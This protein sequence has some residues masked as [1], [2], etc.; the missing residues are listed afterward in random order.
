MPLRPISYVGYV[1][2]FGCL[3]LLD[4]FFV[5]RRLF[6]SRVVA[7]D[8]A[9]AAAAFSAAQIDNYDGPVVLVFLPHL[10]SCKK[11]AWL[12]KISQLN[13]LLHKQLCT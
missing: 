8:A 4:P 7:A 6:V 2:S 10:Q 9:A 1:R 13:S 5:V 12:S 3:F 11:A